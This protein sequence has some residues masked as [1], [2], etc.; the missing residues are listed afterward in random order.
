MSNAGL[1][2]YF[3]SYGLELSDCQSM[4]LNSI[5]QSGRF[6]LR[7]VK[8]MLLPVTPAHLIDISIEVMEG[9]E[10]GICN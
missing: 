10:I 9:I 6:N 8:K 2:R 7:D 4:K 5:I 1:K 3:Q